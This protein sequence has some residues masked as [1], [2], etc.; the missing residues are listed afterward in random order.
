[1]ARPKHDDLAFIEDASALWDTS[2][3][4]LG[5]ASRVFT[6]T[7]LPYRDPGT[8][9]AWG[10]RNGKIALVVTPGMDITSTGQ[11]V[12]TGYPFGVVPRLV[13]TWLTTEAVRKKSP[14]I[15]L[16][17]SLA[18]FMRQLGMAP[19]GRTSRRL[20]DQMLRLFRSQIVVTYDDAER[21]AGARMGVAE[22]WNL[23]WSPRDRAEQLG[24]LPSMVT[25]SGEFFREATERPVPISIEALR[26]LSGSPMRLDI[27]AWLTYRMSRLPRRTQI[28]WSALL[29][30]F[31]SQ[32]T[33]KQARHKFRLDFT[34]HLA[35]VLAVYPDA[36]V[37]VEPEGLILLPS[38][39]HIGPRHLRAISRD[40]GASPR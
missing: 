22:R 12:S 38:P 39:T 10:R 25:L 35:K 1:M 14:E 15:I 7:S 32:A 20:K 27:Y 3:A 19:D 29:L 23:W 5:F 2:D 21:S 28:P 31:G 24:L 26:L 30:Q 40:R 18:D 36:K 11:A 8:I 33:S 6:Q 9:P 37:T 13:L 17:E 4:E 16:G 34:D